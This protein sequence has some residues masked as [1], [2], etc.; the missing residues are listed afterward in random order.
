MDFMVNVMKVCTV[1]NYGTPGYTCDLKCEDN[2]MLLCCY[3]CYV[4]MLICCYGGVMTTP[5]NE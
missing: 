1:I 5:G 2:A 4:A 3:D